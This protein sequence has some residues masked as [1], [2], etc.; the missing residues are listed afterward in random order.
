MAFLVLGHIQTQQD[1]VE[2]KMS[3]RLGP[4]PPC[5]TSSQQKNKE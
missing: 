5:N 3:E 4:K 2:S 1:I